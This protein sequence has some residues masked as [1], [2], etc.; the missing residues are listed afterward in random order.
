MSLSDTL[1]IVAIIPARYG[2]TRLP[3]KVL[4]KIGGRAMVGHVAD[5]ALESGL[6]SKVVVAT[7][8]NRV[9]TYC[10]E[11]KI[12]VILTSVDHRCGTDRIAEVASSMDADVII[13][14]QADEPFITLEQ[15]KTICAAF[16]DQDVDIATL[17]HKIEDSST[18]HDFNTVKVVTDIN[19]RAIY[20]SRQ[21][22]PAQRE[23][24][25]SKWGQNF[26]YYKH[27]GIY[28]YRKETLLELVKLE[29]TRLEQSE[30]LE[31][32]RWLERS[33]RIYV[34]PVKSASMGIDTADD[35]EKARA[36][37]K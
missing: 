19:N 14:I 27:I 1:D 7:D 13:N 21:A 3:G 31:Q 26:D 17:R 4:E 30:S 32:L 15:L 23:L 29:H 12:E 18:I 20:F 9:V 8:A 2:S 6:F 37:Y 34:F 24:P 28:G 11:N 5:R 25:Y 33:Y 10:K 35:L 16:D 36:R 22:I